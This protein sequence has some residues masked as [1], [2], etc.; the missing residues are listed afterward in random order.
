VPP[1]SWVIGGILHFC[2]RKTFLEIFVKVQYFPV[3]PV[4]MITS[5]KPG[6]NDKRRIT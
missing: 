5:G 4:I 3:L 6:V 2:G 1:V